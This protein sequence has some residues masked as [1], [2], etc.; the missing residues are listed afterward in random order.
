MSRKTVQTAKNN[1]GDMPLGPKEQRELITFVREKQAGL[2]I[3]ELAKR[4]RPRI[5]ESYL[6]MLERGLRELTPDIRS[7]IETALK[8]A[9]E[10]HDARA[11]KLAAR[12][13]VSTSFPS[14]SSYFLD[15]VVVGDKTN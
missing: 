1:S 3:A 5:S 12:R 4:V 2:T 13:E 15:R 6:S 11:E 7:R 14:L 8:E 9:C 10:E